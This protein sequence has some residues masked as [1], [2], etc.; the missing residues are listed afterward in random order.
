MKIK[1]SRL[2][3]RLTHQNPQHPVASLVAECLGGVE[4]EQHHDGDESQGVDIGRDAKRRA[5]QETENTEGPD[6]AED[7]G[8]LDNICRQQ[9]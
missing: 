4:E 7:G 1:N 6:N 8:H 2:F 5:V 9:T 3:V